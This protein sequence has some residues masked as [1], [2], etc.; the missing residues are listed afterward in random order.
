MKSLCVL[1]ITG[2][3]GKNVSE[4]V[5]VHQ[6]DFVITGCSFNTSMDV[7]KKIYEDNP[8]IKHVAVCDEETAD[9]VKKTYPELIVYTGDNALRALIKY[10]NYDMVVNALVGFCGFI[11]TMAALYKGIDVALANKESLVVGGHL[12]KRALEE[13]NAKLYPI[14][15]EHVAIAKLLKNRPIEEIKNIHIT[16]SGGSFR[17]YSREELENVSLEK[18]LNH[19]SWNMGAKITI[20]S[21]TMMNK[22]FEII[23]AFYLFDMP[24]DKIKVLMHDESVIHSAVELVDHSF[25]A[26]LGPADMRIPITY[27]L[28]EGNYQD[29]C[30]VEN[31]D[32]AKLSSLHFREFD[33]KRYPAVALAR[34]AISIGHS[35]P[36]VLNA[37]NEVANEA[38]RKGKIPFL[39]IEVLIEKAMNA[40]NVVLNPTATELVDIDWETKSYVKELIEKGEY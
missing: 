15:S 39:S 21:A 1:G 17:D 33:E 26:D 16:A 31:L 5:K 25:I 11:P 10:N 8:S 12:I 18:A 38:F 9:I 40:H 23:E 35:M 32:L 3:I 14:D 22:G 19:P 27:A 4:V 2:S 37:S 34:K 30:D 20:D 29:T 13:G 28:Y 7:F 24:L 36:C 6:D